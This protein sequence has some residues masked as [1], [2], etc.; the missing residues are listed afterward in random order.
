MLQSRARV[1]GSV[2]R[3]VGEVFNNSTKSVGSVFVTA[4]L[5]NASGVLLAT[6]TARTELCLIPHRRPGGRR[7]RR[8]V[9]GRLPPRVVECHRPGNVEAHRGT[10]SDLPHARAQR[11]RPLLR[12]RDG[13]K[14]LCQF[15]EHPP[16]RGDA[17]RRARRRRDDPG[18]GRRDHP[19]GGC[20][21]LVQRHIPRDG[22]GAGQGLRPGYGLPLIRLDETPRE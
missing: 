11:D 17:V 4:K 7:H 22:P 14:P 10:D 20:L 9:A 3:L 13:Q 1:E 21:D 12:H 18:F 15:G 5:Y 19:G 8:H 6:R 16:G 2:L